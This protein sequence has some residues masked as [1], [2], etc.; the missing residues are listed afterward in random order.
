MSRSVKGC[1]P[2]LAVSGSHKSSFLREGLGGAC[3]IRVDLGLNRTN[4]DYRNAPRDLIRVGIGSYVYQKTPA[5]CECNFRSLRKRGNKPDH[6]VR[7]TATVIELAKN[8][9]LPLALRSFGA[10]HYKV[11]MFGSV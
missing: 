5:G 7:V 2:T 9:L 8:E 1:F 11:G 4:A 6:K 10:E 3:T